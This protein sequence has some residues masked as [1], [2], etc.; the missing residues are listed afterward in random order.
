MSFRQASSNPFQF[1][2]DGSLSVKSNPPALPDMGVPNASAIPLYINT[3]APTGAPVYPGKCLRVIEESESGRNTRFLNE[4]TG[5]ELT[6]A[7]A[8][9]A[10]KNGQFPEY[11]VIMCNGEETL[12]SKADGA[13]ANNLG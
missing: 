5:Q 10:A 8:I 1:S 11:D 13:T 7:E 4:I 3:L 2:P 12:R 9:G 6:A